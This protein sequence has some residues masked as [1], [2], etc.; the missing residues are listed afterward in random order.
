MAQ[1]KKKLPPHP[2]RREIIDFAVS[3]PEAWE[4]FPWGESAAKVKKKV[5]A[6]FGME[7]SGTLKLC[8][9]LPSSGKEAL[10]LEEAEVA[11]YGLGK[12]GWV[13]FEYGHDET[14]DMDQLRDWVMES[15][16]VIAPKKLSAQVE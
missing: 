3:L 9:K 13:V 6:F 2:M 10:E 14:P 11:G 4:D 15:Y 8:V 12:S 5:F 7:S 1:E 16:C